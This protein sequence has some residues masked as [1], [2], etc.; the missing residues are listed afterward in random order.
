MNR[1][2][3]RT[4]TKSKAVSEFLGRPCCSTVPGICREVHSDCGC[5]GV[6]VHREDKKSNGG[7]GA[8]SR[9]ATGAPNG[10]EEE[11][12]GGGDDRPRNQVLLYMLRRS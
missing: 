7:H 1:L 11:R 12:G 8:E 9:L 4:L 5:V 2:C 6:L 3:L 10:N